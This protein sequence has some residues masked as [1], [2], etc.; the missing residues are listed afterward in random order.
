MSC[1][2]CMKNYNSSE[3]KPFIISKCLHTVC[4]ECLDKLTAQKCPLCEQLIEN[5]V[6][7][8]PVLELI[9]RNSNNVISIHSN[10]YNLINPNFF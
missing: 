10:H 2:K 1:K 3:N 5:K 6:I 9:E 8:D 4:L 7:N